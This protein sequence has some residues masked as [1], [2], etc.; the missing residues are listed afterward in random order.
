MAFPC[1]ARLATVTILDD[2]IAINAITGVI[3][4]TIQN[5]SAAISQSAAVFQ[6]LWRASLL[7]ISATVCG[8]ST[9][10]SRVTSS[11]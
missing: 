1:M 4:S 3:K 2:C 5:N 6:R 8:D 9:S 10:P 11:S 7:P